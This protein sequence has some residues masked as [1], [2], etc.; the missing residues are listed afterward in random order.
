VKRSRRE[1]K[2]PT[3]RTSLDVKKPTRSD[4]SVLNHTPD[5]GEREN[6]LLLLLLLRAFVCVSEDA[7]FEAKLLL[8]L[9]AK[10]E[11]SFGQKF[12]RKPAHKCAIRFS[13]ER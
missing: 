5:D 11:Q 12:Q 7:L 4:K 9:K 2:K 10:K 13:Y 6:N 1:R 3:P 8:F